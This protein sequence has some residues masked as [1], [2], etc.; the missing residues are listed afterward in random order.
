MRSPIRAPYL[1]GLAAMLAGA[2]ACAAAEDEPGAAAAELDEEAPFDPELDEL[3]PHDGHGRGRG[4]GGRGHGRSGFGHRG[5]PSPEH[6]IERMREDLA[7]TD[8]Q[9]ESIRPILE[10]AHERH[11]ALRDLEPDAR[12]EAARALHE[13]TKSQI[14]AVLT[15]EQQAK[16]EERFADG[17]P[18]FHG[19]HGRGMGGSRGGPRGGEPF[20]DGEPS[21]GAA[22][23]I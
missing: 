20:D 10:A 19:R 4:R 5:P 18:R 7:L 16:L 12:R 6:R 11:E 17:P 2:T 22:G 13:E 1:I 23:A 15:E 8:A 21:P 9:V 14:D 3:G